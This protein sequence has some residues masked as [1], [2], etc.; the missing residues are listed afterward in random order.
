MTVNITV[1]PFSLNKQLTAPSNVSDVRDNCT[2]K[3]VQSIFSHINN[4]VVILVHA[5]TTLFLVHAK[6]TLFLVHAKTT[7][8]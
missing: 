6:T 7:L 2:P 3:L 5:K 1:P 8:F 4:G